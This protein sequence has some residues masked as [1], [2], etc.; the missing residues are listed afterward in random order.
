MRIYVVED[1]DARFQPYNLSHRHRIRESGHR[2]EDQ[3]LTFGARAT[4]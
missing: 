2:K 4:E 3:P 1:G